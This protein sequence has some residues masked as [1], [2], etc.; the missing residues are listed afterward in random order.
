MDLE[1][2]V[3]L[4]SSSWL[5]TFVKM[6]IAATAMNLADLNDDCL[7]AIF[8]LL[9]VRD[10]SAVSRCSRQFNNIVDR[11]T[12]ERMH[13][14]RVRVSANNQ[15][16]VLMRYGED[17]ASLRVCSIRY[18]VQAKN[19][20]RF[21]PKLESLHLSF[22]RRSMFA[23]KTFPA[24]LFSRLDEL[25]I[26]LCHS[27]QGGSDQE[28][29]Q[30]QKIMERCT[31]L[32]K[33]TLRGDNIWPFLSMNSPS[34][35]QV[36]ISDV[37]WGFDN[38]TFREFVKKNKGLESLELYRVENFNYH[39]CLPDL[40]ELK[41]LRE[42]KVTPQLY[43]HAELY[44]LIRNVHEIATL[45]SLA[46]NIHVHVVGSGLPYFGNLKQLECLKLTVWTNIQLTNV[47]TCGIFKLPNLRELSLFFREA[48]TDATFDYLTSFVKNH[49]YI[50]SFDISGF[51]RRM[52][53]KIDSDELENACKTEGITFEKAQLLDDPE[54]DWYTFRDGIDIARV[55]RKYSL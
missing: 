9:G 22:T 4:I 31:R 35:I 1:V 55:V 29:Q 50:K 21:C 7:R 18:V 44:Q 8:N 49:R 53:C 39:R 51:R 11:F 16:P 45:R 26:D 5:I 12:R 42:L 41:S 32:T 38:Q 28:V 23:K 47:L 25:Y 30:I 24:E 36:R 37:R 33:L 43:G 13:Q 3:Q 19:I 6:D 52:S 14:S 40:M 20:I 54:C 27:N 17:I 34:L 48:R 10:L 15:A 46:I 2:A